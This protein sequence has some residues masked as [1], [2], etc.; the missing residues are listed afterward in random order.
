[1][2]QQHANGH[3]F[4]VISGSRTHIVFLAGPHVALL[5][6]LKVILASRSNPDIKRRCSARMSRPTIF[7]PCLSEVSSWERLFGPQCTAWHCNYAV[8]PLCQ[9]DLTACHSFSGGLLEGVRLLVS[10]ILHW[11]L[12]WKTRSDGPRSTH[13]VLVVSARS[14]HF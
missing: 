1:M 6:F 2:S 7:Q 11:T 10:S 3:H 4:W 9:I 12:F 14:N 5:D 13:S 8:W